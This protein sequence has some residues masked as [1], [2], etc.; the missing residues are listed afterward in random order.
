MIFVWNNNSVTRQIERNRKVAI[1][2]KSQES[3]QR[4]GKQW[5]LYSGSSLWQKFI[6]QTSR[7][8]RNFMGEVIYLFFPWQ[9]FSNHGNYSSPKVAL[10]QQS[11]LDYKNRCSSKTTG[12]NNVGPTC[13]DRKKTGWFHGNS[14]SLLSGYESSLVTVLIKFVSHHMRPELII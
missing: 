14:I 11:S 9:L 4:S 13:S 7:M 3:P 10:R 1:E 12:C 2:S 5:R 8:K 6:W